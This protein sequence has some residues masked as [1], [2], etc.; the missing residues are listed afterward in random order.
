MADRPDVDDD[1]RHGRFGENRAERALGRQI[2]GAGGN[3]AG[4]EREEAESNILRGMA[5]L[6]VD[7]EILA[8]TPLA[9]LRILHPFHLPAR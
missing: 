8:E 2:G 4:G 1:G 3:R 7:L 9:K 6:P 5:G